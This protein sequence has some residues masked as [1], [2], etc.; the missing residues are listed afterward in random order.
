MVKK[1]S[2][3]FDGTLQLGKV[4]EYAEELLKKGIDVWVVTTRYDDNNKHR[5]ALLANDEGNI[6]PHEDL[7]EVVDR[8]SIP[9]WKVRFTNWEYKWNYL[10]HTK[11]VW[12]LD[13]N[14]EEFV[15]MKANNCPVPGISVEYVNWMQ[16]C[17]KL[18][19]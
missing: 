19:E 10:Q 8:L 5:Y 6:D 7:W 15:Q 16:E 18:L 13:D 12:H 2:F 3:D 1:V 11:F 17:D 4:Q 9:R 14:P